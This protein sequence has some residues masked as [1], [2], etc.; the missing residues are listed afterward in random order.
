MWPV[1]SSDTVEQVLLHTDMLTLV[2]AVVPSSW[3]MCRALGLNVHSSTAPM[4]DPQLTVVTMKMLVFAVNLVHMV[5]SDWLV[6]H[7]LMR[8]EWKCAKV[9]SGVQ[10]VM[11][12]GDLLMLVW[13]ADSLAIQDTVHW[14]IPLPTLVGGLVP[15]G[16]M[17][18]GVQGLK[19]D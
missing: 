14:P 6:G 17:M 1:G 11:T 12:S 16:L 2:E 19:A 18:P 3:M 5:L 9:A 8:D 15:F 10:C 13:Y 7:W 4:T